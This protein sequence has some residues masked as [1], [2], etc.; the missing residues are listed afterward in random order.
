[1][2]KY[3]LSICAMETPISLIESRSPSDAYHMRNGNIIQPAMRRLQILYLKS[4]IAMCA[5][6]FIGMSTNF[7]ACKSLSRSILTLMSLNF[8]FIYHFYHFHLLKTWL[9]EDIERFPARTQWIILSL[10]FINDK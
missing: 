8:N 10:L 2:A 6:L 9:H 3:I 4:R 1:M 5:K 7:N